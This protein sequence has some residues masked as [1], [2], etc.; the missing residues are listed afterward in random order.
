M[1]V[2][3][4]SGAIEKMEWLLSKFFEAETFSPA[5]AMGM[6]FG[7]GATS[8]MQEFA[9]FAEKELDADGGK[10]RESFDH[11]LEHVKRIFE[12]PSTDP[13]EILGAVME[14]VRGVFL[15]G[16]DIVSKVI[17][18]LLDFVIAALAGAKTAVNEPLNIP[19]VSDFYKESRKALKEPRRNENSKPMRR[20]RRRAHS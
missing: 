9:D 7:G 17:D 5:M 6:G 4:Q 11:A 8:P 10:I 15:L 12:H 16:I 1:D 13:K 18:L 14:V 19:F 2:K 3:G 20:C